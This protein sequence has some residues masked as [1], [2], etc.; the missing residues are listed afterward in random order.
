MVLSWELG[1]R[2]GRGA[3][4]WLS[5]LGRR[6]QQRP[7]CRCCA[8]HGSWV[9]GSCAAWSPAPEAIAK[10]WRGRRSWS[11]SCCHWS[12]ALRR[13]EAP[14]KRDSNSCRGLSDVASSRVAWLEDCA[15]P[16]KRL[17]RVRTRHLRSARRA[18]AMKRPR[19][20]DAQV[21]HE[22]LAPALAYADAG[23]GNRPGPRSRGG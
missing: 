18:Q 8:A 16:R 12:W 6:L 17:W 13:C 3:A 10:P 1:A 20:I 23:R 22:R 5:C 9:P 21:P 14:A 2:L 19:G 11:R 15:V 7:C 4:V